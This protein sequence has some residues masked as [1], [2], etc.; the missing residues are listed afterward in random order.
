MVDV[1]CIMELLSVVFDIVLDG[2]G[3]G[4][5]V[6]GVCKFINMVVEL[7]NGVLYV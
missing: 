6:L 1:G 2:V 7:G 3:C 5:S 4:R